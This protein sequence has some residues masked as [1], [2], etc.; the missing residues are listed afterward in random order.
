MEQIREAEMVQA[1]DPPIL[2]DESRFSRAACFRIPPVFPVTS[3]R[4]TCASTPSAA[5]QMTWTEFAPDSPLEEAGPEPSVLR[6]TP[7]R[8]RDIGSRRAAFSVAASRAD[9]SPSLPPPIRTTCRQMEVTK[10]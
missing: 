10:N 2:V 3:R 6:K 9:T 8:R 1:I 5:V 4:A 7:R